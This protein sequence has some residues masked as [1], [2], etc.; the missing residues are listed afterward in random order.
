[1]D[2]FRKLLKYVVYKKVEKDGSLDNGFVATGYDKL[3]P[4]SQR[5]MCIYLQGKFVKQ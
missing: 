5:R 3:Q 4:S 2:K 1:M